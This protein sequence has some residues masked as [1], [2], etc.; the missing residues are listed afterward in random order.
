[1]S[2][3]AKI[4]FF[5][6]LPEKAIC[7]V[8]GISPIVT[9]V[10]S[11][12]TCTRCRD[13]AMGTMLGWEWLL[14][15]YLY[16]PA[17]EGRNRGVEEV[18]QRVLDR[19]RR[20]QDILD[21]KARFIENFPLHSIDRQ[22]ADDLRGVL[23]GQVTMTDPDMELLD[24]IAT[25]RKSADELPR[26]DAQGSLSDAADAL[27]YRYESALEKIQERKENEKE[28]LEH[29]AMEREAS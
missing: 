9:M 21:R 29:I 15:K 25:M 6:L 8:K 10:P 26:G 16:V 3:K 28:R 5:S 14:E 27:Q 1:M 20:E 24:I 7:G 22:A 19:V 12:V 23:H 17:S 13:Y 11:E 2:N 4:H 18:R